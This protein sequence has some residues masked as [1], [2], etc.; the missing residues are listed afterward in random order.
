MNPKTLLLSLGN[1]A[2]YLSACGLAGTGLLLELRL[3][4]EDGTVRLFG[5]SPDDWGEIH[6]LTAIACFV[7]TVIHLHLNRSWIKTAMAKTKWA[8]PILAGGLGFVA[9]LLL[10]PAGHKVVTADKK[11]GAAKRMTTEKNHHH[12]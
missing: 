7:L 9:V 3:D 5:M 6:I 4:E 2:L 11:A 1:A 12:E 10:W 8:V